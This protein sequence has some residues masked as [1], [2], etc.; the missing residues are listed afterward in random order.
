M[1]KEKMSDYEK[2]LEIYKEKRIEVDAR[3]TFIWYDGKKWSFQKD[4]EDG[5]I[6]FH[7]RS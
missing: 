5:T 1:G 6:T 7:K 4:H 3:G 2:M